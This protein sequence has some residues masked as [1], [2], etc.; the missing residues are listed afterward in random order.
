MPNN[1]LAGFDD[2]VTADGIAI[3]VLTADKDALLGAMAARAAI[4]TGIEADII[5]ERI[6]L[7]EMLGSTGFGGGAAI[8]HARFADL[9]GVIAIMAVTVTPVAFGAI[10]DQP[11]DIAV[12]LL[13]PEAAGADHLKALARISR[14]LRDPVR[15][16]A[17]R[18]A[19][20]DDELR[21]AISAAREA[22][23]RAA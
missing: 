13:S 22:P 19:R 9:P 4:A 8:P 21:T 3:G 17:I 10:D 15:L 18:D 1:D 14:T 5:L 16:N 11:V 7:R 20:T 23:R 6:Q 12:L 2:L